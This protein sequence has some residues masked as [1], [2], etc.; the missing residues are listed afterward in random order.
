MTAPLAYFNGA[1]IPSQEL[2]VSIDDLGFLLGATVVERMRTFAGEVFRADDH[3]RRLNRSLEIVGWNA[4]VL[5]GQVAAA[6]DGIVRRNASL[7]QEG[8]D[9]T[10]VVFITPG[11]TPEAAQP[12]VCVHGHP[13][14]FHQWSQQYQT[15]AEGVITDVRQAPGNC[16]PAELKCR[17]RMH[18]Y[19]ADRQAEATVPGGRAILLDQA[20]KVGEASTANVVAFFE[21]RGL[22]TPRLTQVLPGISQQVL[23]E[24]AASLGIPHT[25]ADLLPEQLATADEIFL[26]STSSCLLPIVRLDRRPVG[27]GAPGP[28]FQQLLAA[29]S[30]LAGVDIAGQ[31]VRFASRSAVPG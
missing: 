3:L 10:V 2:F 29:W 7:F 1:W 16:W 12:T 24:L 27:T 20:G 14:P 31:A 23:F 13:L 22:V 4:Q 5:C 19:L 18:Y 8:D 9:W 17:S 6:I 21:D 26:T 15:G 28:V 11:K 30:K 25:E